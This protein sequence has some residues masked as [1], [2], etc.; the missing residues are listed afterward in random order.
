MARRVPLRRLSSKTTASQGL[1]A[2]RGSPLGSISSSSSC[3]SSSRS[4]ASSRLF[5]GLFFTARRG[6]SSHQL[7]PAVANEVRDAVDAVYGKTLFPLNDRVLGPLEK[8]SEGTTLRPFVFMLGNH[9][10]GKSTFINHLL[11]RRVQQTGVAP[12]DDSFTVIQSGGEDEDRD[13][14][15]LIGNPDLGFGGLR[16]FGPGLINHVNLK[17]RRNLHTTETMLVDSPGM[18][19]SPTMDHHSVRDRGYDFLGVV[20]WFAER[21]DVIL[22]FFDPDKP[23][24]TGETMSC[25]TKA[26]TGYDHKMFI[27]LN[28]VDQFNRIHDF[29][30]AYGS[31]CWN[32]SKVIPR[33]DLP[34]IYTMFIPEHMR[35]NPEAITQLTEEQAAAN[36]DAWL[37][38]TTTTSTA[39]TATTANTAT[40]AAAADGAANGA[41]N[42][43]GAGEMTDSLRGALGDLQQA[44]QEV[45]AEVAKAPERRLD[46]MV[47]QLHDSARLLKMHLEVGDA[48]RGDFASVRWQWL[49][50]SGTV[51]CVANALAGLGFTMGAIQLTA[52]LSVGSV[53]GSYGVHAYGSRKLD[54]L[55]EELLSNEGLNRLFRRRHV[56]QL[57]Q[58]DEFTMALWKR[59]RPQLQVSLRT[60]GLSNFPRSRR[61]DLQAL[62]G[63]LGDQVRSLFGRPRRRRRNRHARARAHFS[64]CRPRPRCDGCLCRNQ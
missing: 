48:A 46:N 54:A 40:T 10:S 59:V 44:R 12:T 29:A 42:G 11:R 58:N 41:A 5:G 57:A 25:L 18:I 20:R 39:T 35:A 37:T 63:I 23:G 47:T 51:F 28:K 45:I 6:L 24:T 36:G 56:V 26:L 61:G 64:F 33:K 7:D 22:L 13:G 27:I 8:D 32:L 15:A 60:I 2:S 50:A 34:R 9:S 43:S 62:D 31:L 3:S 19:D 1:W 49:A 17:V 21:A 14:P 38:T 55:A 53:V 30:R 4:T 16:G 52:A